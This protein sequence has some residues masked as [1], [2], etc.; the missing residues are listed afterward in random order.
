MILSA[1][2]DGFVSTPQLCVEYDRDCNRKTGLM[3][4]VN[5]VNQV[6]AQ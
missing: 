5:A 1:A 6:P 3:G 4:S 2:D